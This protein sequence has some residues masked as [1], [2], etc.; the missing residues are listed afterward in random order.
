MANILNSFLEW[1]YFSS[2]WWNSLF[3]VGKTKHYNLQIYEF[4]FHLFIYFIRLAEYKL[5]FQKFM[6]AAFLFRLVHL[7]WLLI[8][9][10]LWKYQMVADF[11]LNWLTYFVLIDLF[12][13]VLNN[14]IHT[15]LV[16]AF[17]SFVKYDGVTIHQN[18]SIICSEIVFHN[19]FIND[20]LLDTLAIPSVI[21]K[22]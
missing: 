20:E 10:F 11:V 7:A 15:K 9:K 13:L 6:D 12:K 1:L 21:I 17:L 18:W 19:A 16:P 8:T 2:N 14:I 3:W 4:E 22:L 5:I